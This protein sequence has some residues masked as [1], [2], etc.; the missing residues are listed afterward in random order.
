MSDRQNALAAREAIEAAHPEIMIKSPLTS[1][2]GMWELI[3]D[4]G[5]TMYD[6]FWMMADYLAGHYA[7]EPEDS[8][9]G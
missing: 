6:D 4:N 8:G 9:N 1:R 3:S 2:S 7:R 5:T